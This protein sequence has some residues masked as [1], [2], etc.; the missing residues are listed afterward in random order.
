MKRPFLKLLHFTY[1]RI[2]GIFK[3]ISIGVRVLLI[4]DDKVLMVKH[5]YQDE[6]FLV[7]GGAKRHETLAQAA[8]RE[9]MEEAGATLGEMELFGIYT[10]NTYLHTDHIAL[11]LCKDFTYT[12]TG[13]WEID[14][15]EFFPLNVLP[16]DTAPGIR[17]S[18]DDYIEGVKPKEGFGEW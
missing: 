3:P 9:A 8:R 2:L 13:D 6:W 7:G 11:F 12:G 10:K 16:E 18:I 17:R 1:F 14:E 15:I 5:S 4:Q